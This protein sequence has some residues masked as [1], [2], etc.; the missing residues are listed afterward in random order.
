MVRSRPIGGAFGKPTS[1]G[2][3]AKMFSTMNLK[4]PPRSKASSTLNATSSDGRL[5]ERSARMGGQDGRLLTRD[6]GDGIELVDVLGGQEA[7]R[8][9]RAV[10]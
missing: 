10:I 6:E 2:A 5:C 4:E 8:D 9:A 7:H 3:L 1:T